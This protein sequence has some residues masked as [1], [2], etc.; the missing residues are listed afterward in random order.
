MS[1][2]RTFPKALPL[3][4][5]AILVF[6]AG[7]GLA[8]FQGKRQ[9]I[10]DELDSF[11]RE[12]L[13]AF[14]L[15]DQYTAQC[16]VQKHAN[17]SD[18]IVHANNKYAL[19]LNKAAGF[20]YYLDSSVSRDHDNSVYEFKQRVSESRAALLQCSSQKDSVDV[21]PINMILPQ[22]MEGYDLQMVE[23]IQVG[24]DDPFNSTK[25]IETPLKQDVTARQ[26][27]QTLAQLISPYK[28]AGEV[29]YYELKDGTA[30]VV[31]EMDED[32]W[33]GVSVTIGKIRPLVELNLLQYPEIDKV[34]FGRLPE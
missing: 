9:Q 10:T 2:K 18:Y 1:L 11:H 22:D 16:D 30:Y 13:I 32:G 27:A 21:S 14:R 20:P 25:M 15:L 6:L 4:L 24:G 28:M 17:F 5:L 33:A 29:K 26:L 19:V 34:K 7:Y 23:F 8:S 31:F 3:I 12:V